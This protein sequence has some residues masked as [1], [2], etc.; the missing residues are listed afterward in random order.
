[1]GDVTA[2]TRSPPGLE[3]LAG[4]PPRITGRPA[5]PAFD[6]DQPTPRPEDLG[7]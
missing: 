1:M 7:V 6:N 5:L 3:E 2:R 4:E